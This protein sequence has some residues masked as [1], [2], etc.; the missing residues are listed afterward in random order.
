M[1]LPEGGM[2]LALSEEIRGAPCKLSDKE[3]ALL[4]ES[5]AW[6]QALDAGSSGRRISLTAHEGLSRETVRRRLATPP[7]LKWMFTVDGARTQ[8]A[9]AYPDPAKES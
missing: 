2:E 8:L 1:T 7:R 3:T 5:A 9:T 6:T 4:V